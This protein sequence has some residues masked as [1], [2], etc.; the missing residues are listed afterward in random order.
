MKQINKMSTIFLL[1]SLILIG[2]V[3]FAKTRIASENAAD[4]TI[5]SLAGKNI[6]LSEHRGRVVILNFWA[7]WCAPCKEELPFFN[8]LYGKYKDVG[9]E[10]LGVNIDKNASEVRQMSESLK[11]AFAILPDPTG[12]VSNLYKIRSMP[13][14]YVIG[15]DG[16]VRHI[17]WGFGPEEPARYEKEIRALLKE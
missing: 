15:K 10:V 5:K 2:E 16:M 8:H 1:V 17:H 4:F 13:T 3:G 12:K 14:T 11:L 7:T 9:L 6:K